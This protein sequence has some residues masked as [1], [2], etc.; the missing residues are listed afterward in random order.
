[1]IPGL[2]FSPFRF[3]FSGRLDSLSNHSIHGVLVTFLPDQK[4]RRFNLFSFV[5]GILYLV[6]FQVHN[7]LGWVK[8]VGITIIQAN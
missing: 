1:M 6:K 5:L 3:S 7:L 4:A 2:F 8:G